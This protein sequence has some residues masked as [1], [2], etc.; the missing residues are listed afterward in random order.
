VLN[1]RSTTANTAIKLYKTFLN[2]NSKKRK[3]NRA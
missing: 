2:K 1:K 3:R